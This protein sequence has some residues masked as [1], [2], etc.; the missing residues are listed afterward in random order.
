[1]SGL[2]RLNPRLAQTQK[3]LADYLTPDQL[4]AEL[5]IRPSTLK[6]WD[7]LGQNN[8]AAGGFLE[9]SIAGSR[10]QLSTARSIFCIAY[11]NAT[12][13]FASSSELQLEASPMI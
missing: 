4:A 10:L 7:R 11:D 5:G 6:R 2:P 12:A 13:K 1:M 3:L 9:R 8:V